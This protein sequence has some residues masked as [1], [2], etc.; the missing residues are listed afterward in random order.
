MRSLGT[1]MHAPRTPQALI[2]E[3]PSGC[4]LDWFRETTLTRLAWHHTHTGIGWFNAVGS[5][6]PPFLA[7]LTKVWP[8]PE[9]FQLL[10]GG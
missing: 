6:R 2:K 1:P 9:V 7:L 3:G 8:A 10:G 5:V 4:R